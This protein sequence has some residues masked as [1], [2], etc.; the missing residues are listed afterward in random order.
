MIKKEEI[1]ATH[2]VKLMILNRLLYKWPKE[3]MLWLYF[4][5]LGKH[6]YLKSVL[7]DN[8]L[9]DVNYVVSNHKSARCAKHVIESINE[10]AK[11]S[12]WWVRKDSEHQRLFNEIYKPFDRELIKQLN[13]NKP[14]IVVEIGS[15]NGI[16]LENMAKMFPDTHFLGL[17]FAGVEPELPNT[18]FIAGY[19]LDLIKRIDNS[20]FVYATQTLLL[21]LPKELEAYLAEF[22]RMGVNT[23][24][25]F[26]TNIHGYTQKN[27][28]NVW[29]KHMGYNTAWCHNYS[30]YFKKYGY[31]VSEFKQE[32]CKIHPS[33]ADYYLVSVVGEKI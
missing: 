7:F 12:E 28:G 8:L 24:C 21:A 11:D 1:K 20:D 17:D 10:S 6:K 32:L 27:D 16:Q 13:L 14:K 9:K 31:R 25:V 15:G 19:P 22:K 23:I 26:D 30:G 2:P 4:K 3:F 5:G 18:K 33:R 29:S